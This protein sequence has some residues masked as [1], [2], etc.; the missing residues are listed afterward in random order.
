MKKT[1]QIGVRITEI[2]YSLLESYAK[3]RKWSM[4]F[5]ASE[6]LEG[7]LSAYGAV[8]V[9][10]GA[11]KQQSTLQSAYD[12]GSASSADEMRGGAVHASRPKDSGILTQ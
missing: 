3:E 7:Y 5:S 2:C 9:Q 10:N 1:K 12:H 11:E 6:I 4:A 8:V